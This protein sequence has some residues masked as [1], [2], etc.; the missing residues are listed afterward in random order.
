MPGIPR[1]TRDMTQ[2][3]RQPR[4]RLPISSSDRKC[5]SLLGRKCCCETKDQDRA[6][7]S[8]SELPDCWSRCLSGFVG[9]GS[10][11]VTKPVQLQP[12]PGLAEPCCFLQNHQCLRKTNPL[13]MVLWKHLMLASATWTSILA[14]RP[15]LDFPIKLKISFQMPCKPHRYL[16][17]Q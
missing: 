8:E 4:V 1:D 17:K 3:A 9:V 15:S 14:T 11:L 5:P 13:W 6:E 2:Q 7:L 12:P 10:R 16:T